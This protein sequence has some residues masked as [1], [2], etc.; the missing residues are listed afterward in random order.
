M[1]A[2]W[3]NLDSV[4]PEQGHWSKSST[5]A[6]PL[7]H[8]VWYLPGVQSRRARR[9]VNTPGESRWFN[10]KRQ[11]RVPEWRW[12]QARHDCRGEECRWIRV[13]IVRFPT[14]YEA[15]NR[16]Q[17]FLMFE[18]EREPRVLWE[19]GKKLLTPWTRPLC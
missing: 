6:P 9:K 18:I 2:G 11:H 4:V 10:E 17:R 12:S 15:I 16:S 3:T 19:A 7:L 13:R 5:G 8:K 14:P 1:I